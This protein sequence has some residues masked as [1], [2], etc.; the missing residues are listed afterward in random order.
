MSGMSVMTRFEAAR[1]I[2]VRAMQLSE[3]ATPSVT[4]DDPT[5]CQDYTYVA[6]NE[7][8]SGTLDVCILREKKLVHVSSLR[9]PQD[10]SSM[11]NTRDGTS[12]INR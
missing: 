2:G 5:L 7:L 1:V 9:L 4:I 6:A 12:R 3:G 10:V 8:V 11:I